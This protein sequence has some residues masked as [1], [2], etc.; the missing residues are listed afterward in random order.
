MRDK[1]SWSE[2]ARSNPEQLTIDE[3]LAFR[4][5]ESSHATILSLVEETISRLGRYHSC[6]GVRFLIF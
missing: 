2:A 3:F 1:A 5:P 6:F 4:H